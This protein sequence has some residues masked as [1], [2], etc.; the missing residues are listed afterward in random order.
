MWSYTYLVWLVGI[1]AS[2]PL[3]L[4][5]T[6]TLHQ[7][8][9]IRLWL[10]NWKFYAIQTL[11]LGFG[12][13]LTYLSAGS[14]VAVYNPIAPGW[15]IPLEGTLFW[16]SRLLRSFGPRPCPHGQR[17]PCHVYLTP[18]KNMSNSMFV[19][20]HTSIAISSLDIEYISHKGEESV[21]GSISADQFEVPHLD[22]HDQRNVYS[23]YLSDL[24]PDAIV[25]FTI[26]SNDN[27]LSD[28]EYTFRTA[29]INGE[30]KFLVGGDAGTSKVVEEI[31]SLIGEQSPLFA[32]NG[33]DVA[34][35]NGMFTC[36]CT[37]DQYLWEWSKVT[38]PDGHMIPLIFAIG[39][40]DIG[41]NDDNDGAIEMFM[42]PKQCDNSKRENSRPLY[43]AYFPFEEVGGSAPDICDRKV[44]HVHTAGTGVTIWSLDSMYAG[45]PMDAVQFV[46]SMMPNMSGQINHFAAYHVP[47]YS[48]SKVEKNENNPMRRVWP[49]LILDKYSFKVGF[50]HHAHTF[51]R[52]KP[53][54]NNSVADKG[55]VYIG[56]GKWGTTGSQLPSND[57]IIKGE[58]FVKSGT[59]HHV[60]YVTANSDGRVG[61][62]AINNY[63][64]TIDKVDNYATGYWQLPSQYY[65]NL[66]VLYPLPNLLNDY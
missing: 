65:A 23:A 38:T 12:I 40:H 3:I 48:N 35:D 9:P 24:I 27:K 52:T 7:I 64:I 54:T 16:S 21:S 30:V 13:F 55:V 61:L 2:I 50:E 31:N 51:K 1:A 29:P 22:E 45:G 19:N 66:T 20:V 44:N 14:C 41:A 46:D 62:E 26:R 53:M 18:A 10:K 17:S 43:I 63:G 59:D 34:Y 60:W 58:P 42:D 32:I 39:N 8:R 5:V 11:V 56:D 15:W 57:S 37:W 33:G 6:H 25:T 4:K 28:T 49:S 47:M 36:A